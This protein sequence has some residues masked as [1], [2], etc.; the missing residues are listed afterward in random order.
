MTAT[1]N[2]ELTQEPKALQGVAVDFFGDSD[3]TMAGKCPHCGA[4]VEMDRES[5]DLFG[6]VVS[7][8]RCLH[9]YDERKEEEAKAAHRDE[10][11]ESWEHLCPPAYAQPIDLKRINAD[12]YHTA[13]G[14]NP[15]GLVKGLLMIG[16]TGS[17]KTRTLW[18]I[19]KRHWEA[20]QVVRVFAL[21]DFAYDVA[22][23]GREGGEKAFTDRIAR[24]VDLLAFDDLGN[25]RFTP[26]VESALLDIL[27]RRMAHLRP[28]IITT[29]Y[30]GEAFIQRFDKRSHEMAR[31]TVR[32]LRDYCQVVSFGKNEQMEMGV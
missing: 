23:A 16:D 21:N 30:R 1:R 19:V 18:P 32:R 29:Q 13:L 11:R 2:S 4:A 22:D 26:T 24:Q 28:L 17:G 8:E 27:E 7:C 9:D 3:A 14:W 20:G 6:A 31:A 12:A 10:L 15:S 25:H 5:Y